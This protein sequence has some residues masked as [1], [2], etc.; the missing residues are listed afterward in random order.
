MLLKS[1]AWINGKARD[2]CEI[3]K[4]V[5]TVSKYGLAGTRYYGRIGL[6]I[7]SIRSVE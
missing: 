1:Q 7:E 3:V 2:Q 6:M 4:P 5:L